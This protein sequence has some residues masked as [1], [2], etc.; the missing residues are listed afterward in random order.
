MI[1]YNYRNE[2][3]RIIMKVDKKGNIGILLACMLIVAIVTIVVAV[4]MAKKDVDDYQ[5]MKESV[6]QSEAMVSQY[7]DALS[8]IE[9]QNAEQYEALDEL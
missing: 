3:G 5:A 8:D 7:N 6:S 2:K 9:E 1:S 4:K